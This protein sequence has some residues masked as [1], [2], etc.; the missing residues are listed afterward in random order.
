MTAE[1]NPTI[2]TSRSVTDDSP[3]PFGA[4][5]N[6]SG[7]TEV[8]VAIVGTGFGGLGTAVAL[9]RAGI[10]DFVLLERAHEVG[11]TWRAN[12]YPGC[13]CDVPSTLYSFSFAPNP[14]WT[15]TYPL[16]SEI[17]D[18]LRGVA[19]DYGLEAHLRFGHDVKAGRWDENRKRWLLETT[20]GDFTAQLVVLGV[21]ALSEPSI[22]PLPG[23]EDFEGA[24]FHSANWDHEH[25]LRGERVAVIGT[26]ASAIQF[27]PEIQPE[28]SELQIYQRTAPWIMPHPDR[29]VTRWERALWRA[30]PRTQH[31][32]RAGVYA[33]RETMVLGLT[34]DP[35]LMAGMEMVARQH[36]R[37]QVPDPDLRSKLRPRYRLGCKRILVSE[38]YYPAVCE[39]NVEVVTGGVKQVRPHSIVGLDGVERAV[40][41]IICGTGFLVTSPPS[42]AYVRGRGGRRLSEAWRET[43]SAYLGTTIAG[44]PNA[45]MLTG[46]NTGLGHSSM[47]YMIESQINY[48]VDALQTMDRLGVD[49]VDVRPEVQDA[50]NVE[51]QRKLGRSVWSLGGCQSWYMDASGRNTTLWPSFTFRFRARTRTFNPADY[52]LSTASVRAPSAPA[53]SPVTA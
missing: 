39:D 32:W 7:P 45:F 53:P 37:S 14:E 33:A 6:G 12:T 22:P 18:Y 30:F 1:L 11:G 49:A 28:V 50:Y 26:G 52:T 19:R 10:E 4:P 46:P 29:A 21:G 3:G 25:D 2:D 38:N 16:Q 47:V 34:R 51:L 48:V 17:W 43:M 24:I 15:R 23:L 44:F 27:V 31:L 20:G 35:R 8:R 42:A 41:T 13:Q 36:L 5:T 40:D 9:K